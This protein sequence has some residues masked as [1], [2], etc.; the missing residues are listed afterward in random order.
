MIEMARLSENPLWLT[1]MDLRKAY[2]SVDR[3]KLFRALA[4][5]LGISPSLVQQLRAMYTGVRAYV[6]VRG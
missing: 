4:A 2:D 1:F 5:D 3:A 6:L